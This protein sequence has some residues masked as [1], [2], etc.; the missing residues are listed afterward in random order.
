[1][2]GRQNLFLV[3]VGIANLRIKD[4]AFAAVFATILL[5][6]LG[7]VSV[8]NNILALTM[9]AK[10]GYELTN[11]IQKITTSFEI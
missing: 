8:L 5:F 2:I 11:H 3:F 7:I 9:W 1:M 6:A 4:T 10:I